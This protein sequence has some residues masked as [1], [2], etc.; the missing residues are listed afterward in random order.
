MAAQDDH[1]QVESPLFSNGPTT[2]RQKTVMIPGED[3][4][5]HTPL[6]LPVR[7]QTIFIIVIIILVV[8]I[9]IL[10]IVLGTGAVLPNRTK[11]PNSN[12]LTAEYCPYN[13]TSFRNKCY[14]FSEEEGDWNSSYV[15]CSSNNASLARIEE[16]EESYCKRHDMKRSYWI[17]VQ[18]GMGETRKWLN[19][20][21]AK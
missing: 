12:P 10:T 20:D 13:W 2:E 14:Y 11:Q 5:P 21:T 7:R 4:T 3:R 16:D 15:F 8:I 9:V 17:G 18:P 19:G 6:P 1:D